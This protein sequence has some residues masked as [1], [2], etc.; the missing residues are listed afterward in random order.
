MIT[1]TPVDRD[2]ASRINPL[3]STL[4]TEETLDNAAFTVFELG[5][6]ATGQNDLATDNLYHLFAAIAA[7]LRWERE[8]I[9]SVKCCRGECAGMAR[10]EGEQS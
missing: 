8:N 10:N 7:A 3:I 1:T 4:W 2:T 6:L 5:Y 9:L